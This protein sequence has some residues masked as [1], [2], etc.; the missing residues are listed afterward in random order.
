MLAALRALGVGIEQIQDEAP[1]KDLTLRV[2]GR[3]RDLVPHSGTID[4]GPA[5]TAMRFLTALCAAIPGCQIELRGSERMHARPIA[6]LVEALRAAGASINYLGLA[7][8]PPLQ[9][10]SLRPLAGQN[11]SIDGSVSSQFISSLLL[12]APLFE[13]GLDLNI[14]GSLTSTSYLEMT[15]QGLND[16]GLHFERHAENRISVPANQSYKP[17]S[18]RIEG[19]AS[20]AS[21][22]WAIAA[23]SGGS[24]TVE[25]INPNSKQGDIAFPRLLEQM[26]CEIKQTP[27]SITVTGSPNLEAIDVDMELMPDTAQT[28]A[29]V[30]ACAKGITRI[31]GLKTL[32]VKETDRIEA[33]R[34][35]LAK[36][37]I[38]SETG[39]DSITIHGGNPR[40]A[41]ISTYDDHRMAM[42]FAV[43]ASRIYGM[44]IEEPN[45]VEKSFPDFWS[46]INDVG[47]SNKLEE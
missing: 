15:L 47:I 37:G 3:G 9:I 41:S 39:E 10:A 22:L 2:T 29:T 8:C 23:V 17:R 32:R 14:V 19:D 13:G 45:V 38:A 11:I 26:G 33:L 25:N 31:S 7:G 16:F 20:G 44:R 18:Y 24:V 43:L 5:G 34:V 46:V 1:S 28:L 35:E 6:P 30:A 4:V 36:C 27:S 42:S 40:P 21:Y 12:A